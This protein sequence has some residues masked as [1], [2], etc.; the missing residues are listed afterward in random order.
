MINFI[1]MLFISICIFT[2]LAIAFVVICMFVE[3]VMLEFDKLIE[4]LRN[5]KE[6]GIS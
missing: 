2:V 6:K 4:R 1:Y 3:M 5:G